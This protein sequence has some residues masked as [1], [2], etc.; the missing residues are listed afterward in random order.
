MPFVITRPSFTG[1]PYRPRYHFLPPA[2]WMNDPN[3]VIEIDGRYHLFY[4]HNPDAP[5]WGNIHW[6]HA[7]SGDLVH[8][9]DQPIALAPDTSGLDEGGVWSGCAVRHGDEVMLIYTGG[10]GKFTQDGI[11]NGLRN[12]PI[13]AALGEP[14]LQTWRKLPDNPLIPALPD[15]GDI[16][17]VRDPVVWREGDRWRMT[18]GAG[19]RGRG[20]AVL[21]YDSDDLHRWHYAGLLHHDNVGLL[22]ECPQLLTFD[23]ERA[24][25]LVSVWH[26]PQRSYTGYY[27]GI[28]RHG[29]F[30]PRFFELLE[31]ENAA[32]Y[33]PQAT[34]DARGRW[35]MWGWIREERS[36]DESLAAG[37]SGVMSLPRVVTMDA[38]GHLRQQPAPEVST[39]RQSAA[40]PVNP[41]RDADGYNLLGQYASQTLEIVAE[42]TCAGTPGQVELELRMLPGGE[43]RLTIA[44]DWARGRLQIGRG[45]SSLSTSDEADRADLTGALNLAAGEAL[46][47]HIYVDH[48]V[49]EVFANEGLVCAATRIYPTHNSG[50]ALGWQGTPNVMLRFAHVWNLDAT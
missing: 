30:E 32:L 19:L 45:Q 20:G 6:G 44:Y 40:L 41:A 21:L 18:I 27:S 43:E 9:Q 8:W 3:G 15:E 37:W 1:D 39:L 46:K 38:D 28:Y 49:V 11:A 29:K 2:G 36:L 5:V 10:T 14:G 13:C 26:P 7:V 48:S 35:L 24:A 22:W 25:L 33:A 31:L 12:M 16:V 42:F 17:G 34:R 23:D 50:I 4:Q 47:L